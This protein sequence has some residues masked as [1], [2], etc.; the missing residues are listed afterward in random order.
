MTLDLIKFAFVAG[1]VS[2]SYYG[3][4]DLEKFDL[5]LAEA[6]NWFVDY[7]GGIS[8]TPGTTLVDYVQHDQFPTKFFKFAFSSD[9]A[10]TN[11]I[12]F[13]KD[14][15]RFIQDGAYVLE[16]TKV[17][18]SISKAVKGVVTSASHGLSTGDWIVWLSVGEMLE[19]TL[20]TCE[21]QV[22]GINTF[23]L[24]DP[25]GA[26]LD[27]SNFT[28]YVSGGTF[29]RIYTLDSPYHYSELATLQAHQIRDVIRLTHVNHKPRNLIRN[30]QADWGI[31]LETFNETISRPTI[32][33]VTGT[34]G[35]DDNDYSVGYAVTAIDING[36]ETLP[37]R[38]VFDTSINDIM[39]MTR[40]SITVK[41]SPINGA[42]KYKV[43]RTRLAFQS[44]NVSIMSYSYQLGYVGE[45][46]GSHFVDTGITPDFSQ[47]PPTAYNP[48]ADGAIRSI[49]VTSGTG[50]YSNS[51]SVSISDATG[52]GFI[53]YPVISP[54][55]DVSSSGPAVGV[56]I[57][58][59]G[60]NYTNPTITF[61]GSGSATA[62]LSPASGN[63]PRV[64]TVF[65]QRQIYAGTDNEPLTVF[66]SKPGQL[67]NFNVSRI[68]VADDSFQHE[69]DSENFSPIIHAIPTRGGLLVFSAGGIWLMSGSQ[70]NAVTA[71]DVQA[72]P[73]TF[74]GASKLPP[75]KIDTDILYSNATGGRVNALAYMDS[76]KLY[77]PT[78]VSLLSN[79]LLRDNKHIV[80]WGYADEPHRLIHAVR[81]DGTMLLFT[82]IKDQEVYAWTR[83]TTKGQF[84]DAIA[85][86][87]NNESAV[88]VMVKRFVN[89][90]FTKFIERVAK[91]VSTPSE[92]AVYLDCSLQLGATYPQGNLTIEATTGD[93]VVVTSDFAIFKA[94]DVNKILR[95]GNGK[96]RV[97]TFV[98]AGKIT[99]DIIRDFDLVIPF[100]D[101]ARP[102]Q[103]TIGNWT[104]DAEVSTIRGLHHLEGQTVTVLAD[105]AI[106]R[107]KVVTNGTIT[108][109]QAASRVVVG[110]PYKSTAKN[111]PLNV[112]G[113]VVENKRKRIVGICARL[114]DTRGLKFGNSLD[115]LYQVKTRS[116]E[117][118]GEAPGLLNGMTETLIEPVWDI[119]G[120][121]YLVQEDPLP[122]TI[123]GYVLQ[124]E[125]G[126]DPD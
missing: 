68:L 101:P 124:T 95:F 16:D 59:G 57:Y 122:A 56:L 4:A 94:A 36:V 100:E 81:A 27:T 112:P 3:R 113:E 69:I 30:G 119:E 52:S 7:H 47:T 50:P 10:N 83:R 97:A 64:A 98:N 65:Q 125:V 14:Y 67:S 18:S 49:H 77:T 40:A 102:Q 61:S 9:I 55:P 63:N 126:D 89:G 41:W 107:N 17:A 87:E 2:D 70:G 75:L 32:S 38:M 104:L 11:V 29:A 109:A 108:L 99:V 21:V 42:V 73:Q 72:D 85:L 86:E 8:N 66:G 51:T 54:T 35:G 114:K 33:S 74:T 78:D 93:G 34:T 90:R 116:I 19:L 44:N 5:A 53:G 106:I 28:T 96:A 103:A 123:L 115:N 13:G 43:Y 88:Y 76:Y 24:L 26:F 60:E 20:R 121:S 82:M 80:A 25:F 111:L 6:E 71:V 15:I 79:H 105:G 12:L 62:T 84:L 22:T 110:I 31:E 39:N 58:D 37:S 45:T 118:F 1:E 120:Q 91:R 117:Q 92:E 23:Y 48:F 46:A